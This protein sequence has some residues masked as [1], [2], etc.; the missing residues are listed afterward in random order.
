MFGALAELSSQRYYSGS[1]GSSFRATKGSR[2]ISCRSRVCHCKR[3]FLD[4]LRPLGMTGL[5]SNISTIYQDR[6]KVKND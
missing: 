2:G 3:R 5:S 1:P 6:R 4:S